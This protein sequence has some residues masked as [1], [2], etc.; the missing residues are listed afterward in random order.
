[1]KTFGLLALFSIANIVYAQECETVIALSKIV[2]T[3]VSDKDSVDQHAA[4][5]CNEYAR[6][7]GHSSNTNFGASYKFLSAS[8]GN[9]NASVD[10]VASKY[11]SASNNYSARK[12]VYRQYIESISP[13]A[14][15]AYEQCLKMTQ[16]DLKFNVNL[17]SILPDQFS[18][19]V[20]FT[21]QNTHASST[22]LIYSTSNGITCTWDGNSDKSL[23]MVSGSTAVLECS[24][25]DQSKKG[26][27]S[28]VRKDDA[29]SQPLTLPWQGYTR[30]GIPIGT[31]DSII[32]S[33]S[34]IDT[35]VNRSISDIQVLSQKVQNIRTLD[36]QIFA[37][38]GN[39]GSVSCELFCAGSQ[40]GATGTCVGAQIAK[41]PQIGQY[42][43]CSTGT[44]TDTNCWCS[45]F[46]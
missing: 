5:F 45:N 22:T 25:T 3:T 14:Y 28:V 30:D 38:G 17:A 11:C 31:V 39:N 35:K 4:N 16:Q 36:G 27:V 13:N 32:N 12:D 26:Y 34:A 43:S 42:V 18:M 2:T 33:L 37:K 8:Y 40:W 23:K 7:S 41:G 24:R 44:A 46:H 29:S 15:G 9:S 20:A 1:M 21:S 10:E 19:S 6:S